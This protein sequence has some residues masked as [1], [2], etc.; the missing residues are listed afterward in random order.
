MN[1]KT[2]ILALASLALTANAAV[3]TLY[4]GP[5]CTGTPQEDVNVWDNT[6]ATWMNGFQS[7]KLTTP[8]G[9]NQFITTYSRNAC[10]GTSYN[11]VQ[12]GDIGLCLNSFGVNFSGSN[13]VC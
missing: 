10:A 1:P 12:A 6:C 5:D 13:A 7:F 3:M 8:G 2:A 11:C 4:S 9:D